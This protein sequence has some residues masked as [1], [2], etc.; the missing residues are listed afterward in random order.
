[1]YAPPMMQKLVEKLQVT[2]HRGVREESITVIAVVIEKDF[3]RYYD[4]IMPMLKQFVMHAT[5]ERENRLRG[6]AFECMSLLGIAVGKEKFCPDA[7][8]AISEMMKTPLEADDVQ[9]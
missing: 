3:S 1:M 5:G 9:R 6:K 2:Q 8:E 7:Q 4:G